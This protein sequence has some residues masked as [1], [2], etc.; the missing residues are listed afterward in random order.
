[1]TRAAGLLML[2]TAMGVPV[3]VA[4]A[5]EPM[6]VYILPIP[7]D[8]A[9]LAVKSGLAAAP[10]TTSSAFAVTIDG[11]RTVAVDTHHGAVIEGLNPTAVHTVHVK[12]GAKAFARFK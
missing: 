7:K 6:T 9:A 4:I 11:S 8:A 10:F 3:V 12:L 2:A 5:V 1:M